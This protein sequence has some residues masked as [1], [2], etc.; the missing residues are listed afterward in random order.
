LDLQ[1]RHPPAEAL[2]EVLFIP[3]GGATLRIEEVHG[4]TLASE[5]WLRDQQ[6]KC[7]QHRDRGVSVH[8]PPP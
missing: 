7:Q 5:D 6:S 3:A 1:S 4:E 2:Q 8:D